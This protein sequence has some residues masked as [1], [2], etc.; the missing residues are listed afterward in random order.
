MGNA[1]AVNGLWKNVCA[2]GIFDA[3]LWGIMD[4]AWEIVL[5]ALTRVAERERA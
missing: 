4:I 5:A 1:K 2:L 3:E